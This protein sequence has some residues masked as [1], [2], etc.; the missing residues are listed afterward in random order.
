MRRSFLPW[1]ALILG[2]GTVA[3]GTIG[4]HA[5]PATTGSVVLDSTVALQ[6]SPHEPPPV[7]AAAQD[8]AADFEKVLG[9]KPR[10]ITGV[11]GGA[12]ASVVIGEAAGAWTIDAAA[13]AQRRARSR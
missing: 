2:F 12:T 9:K 6:L 5:A 1:L 3:W 4:Q 13:T 11:E 10:I 7:A 8:L